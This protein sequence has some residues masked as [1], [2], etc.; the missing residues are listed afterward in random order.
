MDPIY[1]VELMLNGLLV[2]S[3]YAIIALGF[4]L[5]YKASDVINFAQGEFVM[6]AGYVIAFFLLSMELPLWGA[7]ILAVVVMVVVGYAVEWLVLQHLIG[8]PVV[9]VIMATIGLAS[10]LQG[11]AQFLFGIETRNVPLPI[12]DDPI[13]IGDVLLNRV[14]LIAAVLA[15]L[16]FAAIGWFFVKSRSGIAL[17]AIADDQQVSQAM[18]ID[19]R[20]YFALA[21]AIAGIV[22]LL[23]GI[24]WGN[25]TGVDVQLALIG[26]KVFPV[27]I[28]G[29]LDSIVGAII[30][31]LV[32]GLV[33]SMAAGFIDPIVGG[34]TKDLTP[35]VLMILVLMIRP[36]GLFGKEIIERV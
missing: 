5:I 19:V 21:W 32:V 3:L 7:A 23:G 10:F 27:V 25:A 34:G 18:G 1:V 24:F 31:G 16:G 22:A 28:L 12:S 9:A 26:L 11:L 2:G 15:G 36:Y 29:G 35:Y 6:F 20:K 33:E 13:F 30:A 17:R 14:E 4:V 8:R